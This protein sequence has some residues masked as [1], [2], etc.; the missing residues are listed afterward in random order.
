[1]TPPGASAMSPSALTDGD[2]S[3]NH[4]SASLLAARYIAAAA[5][6]GDEGDDGSAWR[7]S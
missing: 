7:A 1:M 6:G 4:V 5:E 2:A 3:I